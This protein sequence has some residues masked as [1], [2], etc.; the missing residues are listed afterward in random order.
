MIL[1]NSKINVIVLK[2]NFMVSIEKAF[3]G[4]GFNNMLLSL[5]RNLTLMSLN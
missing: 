2:V 1:T 4:S 3:N 5:C